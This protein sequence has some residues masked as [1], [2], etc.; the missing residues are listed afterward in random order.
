MIRMVFRGIQAICQPEI[1][2]FALFPQS[3]ELPEL[4][5]IRAWSAPRLIQAGRKYPKYD[6]VASGKKEDATGLHWAFVFRVMVTCSP[7]IAAG[8]GPTRQRSRAGGH[9]GNR[10]FFLVAEARIPW[11]EV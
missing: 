5:F 10:V 1:T 6:W 9:Q 8:K 4:D 7:F 3:G 2:C 11:H